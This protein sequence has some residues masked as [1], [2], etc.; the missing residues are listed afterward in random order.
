MP[1]LPEDI[2]AAYERYVGE[3]YEVAGWS[4]TYRGIQRGKGDMGIDLI[5]TKGQRKILVQCKCW[6]SDA[7]VSHVEVLRFQQACAAHVARNETGALFLPTL[8]HVARR[9]YGAAFITSA[10][11]SPAAIKAARECSPPMSLR[12]NLRAPAGWGTRSSPLMDVDYATEAPEG[13]DPDS[14]V[15]EPVQ[16]TPSV[17]ALTYLCGCWR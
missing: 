15:I 10:R 16:E 1:A 6:Q 11:F 9:E 17:P 8:E 12:E 3:L 2:G 7:E 4:V 5:A 13:Y 14:E